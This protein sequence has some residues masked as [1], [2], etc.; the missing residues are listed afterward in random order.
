MMETGLL[1]LRCLAVTHDL[2]FSQSCID[3]QDAKLMYVLLLTG[4]SEGGLGELPEAQRLHHCMC[5]C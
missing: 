2:R 5:C 4:S 1:M 3:C